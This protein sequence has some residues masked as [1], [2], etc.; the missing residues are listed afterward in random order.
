VGNG[1]FY[2][3]LTGNLLPGSWYGFKYNSEMA[4]AMYPFIKEYLDAGKP[5][6]KALVDKQVEIYETKFPDWIYAWDNLMAGRTVISD[7]S[8]DFDVI[9]RKFPYRHVQTY[10]HDFSSESFEKLAR[11]GTKFVI[12]HSDNRRKL[13]VVKSHFGTLAEWKPDSN[14]DFAYAHMLPDKTELVVINLVTMTLEQVFGS[15]IVH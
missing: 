15:A 8:S 4:K 7:D 3:K 5:M 2:V 6:D 10:L 11:G 9:D 14:K 1:Y 13:D 12:I